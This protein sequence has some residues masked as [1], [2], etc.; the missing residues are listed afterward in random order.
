MT[1]TEDMDRTI[2]KVREAEEKEKKRQKQMDANEKYLA[3]KNPARIAKRKTFASGVIDSKAIAA[4]VKKWGKMNGIF[5]PYDV[6][7]L[8]N[9]KQIVPFI[10]QD[11]RPR[12]T[13]QPSKACQKYKRYASPYWVSA[14]ELFLE[15][16][17]GLKFPLILGFFFIRKRDSIFD[18][19]N[20]IQY[21]MDLMRD[22]GWIPDDSNLYCMAFPLGHIIDSRCPGVV[23]IPYSMN[24]IPLID[25]PYLKIG[26]PDAF[27]PVPNKETLKN[28]EMI[29]NHKNPDE[30]DFYEAD[31]LPDMSIDANDEEEDI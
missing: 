9:S 12:F 17:K 2:S 23:V 15:K 14:R 5:I 22:F 29:K 13:L 25:H 19:H 24:T 26:F 7:S 8:K 1:S 27:M 21:P 31:V 30:T 4:E 18:Y 3:K 20:M 11:G 10:D 6:A 28:W 16:I